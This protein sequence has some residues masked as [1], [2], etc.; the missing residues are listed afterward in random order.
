MNN[1]IILHH[2]E[3][4]PYAEKIRLMFG[5]TNTRWHSLLSPVYPPRP[6]V[7]PLTG[8]YRR[9]P[10]AQ[11][12]A[13]I[14]CDTALIAQE[15]ATV[16]GSSALDSASAEGD[17]LALMKQAEEKAFFAAVGAVPPLRLLGTM[18][19]SF[20]P[21][22]TYR[23]A[24]DRSSLLRGGTSRPPAAAKAAGVLQSFLDA[25]EARLAAYPWVGGDAPTVAD[26]A[27]FHPLWLHVSC[28]RKPLAA[29]ANV[30][31][32]YKAVEEFGHGQ[33]KEITQAEAF[34]AASAS[35]PRALPT[36]TQHGPLQIGQVV[37]V[38]PQDYGVVPVMGRL[39]AVTE[40]RIIVAR[41][42]SAFG[43]LHVH[44]PRAGYSLVAG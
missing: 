4:S 17:A 9:I 12:G 14:F 39:A 22:G 24:K 10:V 28:N 1:S 7:D 41:E 35:Q 42:S 8:G 21:I 30:L 11:I 3:N 13:D 18:L 5:F 19:R 15:V 37:Q 6:N 33:R 20:G 26:F 44:F 31:R 2:Y 36:S 25:L 40:N 38:A 34:A 16:T 23:F 27:C 29:G 43:T 32:W